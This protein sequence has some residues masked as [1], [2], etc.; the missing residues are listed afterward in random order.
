MAM[1]RDAATAATVA[2][3]GIFGVG[4]CSPFSVSRKTGVAVGCQRQRVGR[5]EGAVESLLPGLTPRCAS[6][7]KE[8]FLQRVV[9]GGVDLEVPLV[10]DGDHHLRVGAVVVH[11]GW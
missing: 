5:P 8:Q 10:F 7:V 11:V 2:I 1:A 4:M 6:A 9:L 3:L